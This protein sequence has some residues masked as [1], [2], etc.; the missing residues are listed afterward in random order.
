MYGSNIENRIDEGQGRGRLKHTDRR[1]ILE[2]RLS[3][4]EQYCCSL[5]PC[6]TRDDENVVAAIVSVEPMCL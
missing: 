4:S 3:V 6:V 1:N 5:A 2:A